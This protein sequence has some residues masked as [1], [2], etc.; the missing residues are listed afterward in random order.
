[1]ARAPGAGEGGWGRGRVCWPRCPGFYSGNRE[2]Q[3]RHAEAAVPSR[4]SIFIP[5]GGQFYPE[6]LHR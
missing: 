5:Q 4:R 3:D 1:M 2:A 6:G